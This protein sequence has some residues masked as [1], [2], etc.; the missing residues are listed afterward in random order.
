MDIFPGVNFQNNPNELNMRSQA[1][2]Y[3][4]LPVFYWVNWDCE[5]ICKVMASHPDG[6]VDKA[7]YNNPLNTCYNLPVQTDA[8]PVEDSDVTGMAK[9]KQQPLNP[10][11]SSEDRR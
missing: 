2:L 3:A 8:L 11:N 1:G 10:K 5:V 9:K 6:N 7:L 4:L